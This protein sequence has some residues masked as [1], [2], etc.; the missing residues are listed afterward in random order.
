MNASVGML[1]E[2]HDLVKDF[3]RVRAV[4]GISFAIPRGKIVGL[5]GPN[6][7]GKT[8][9][10]HMLLGITGLTS[11]RITYF[12][13]EFAR[14]RQECLQRINYAS[15]FNTLQGRISV[16][17]N[18]LVFSNLYAIRNAGARIRKLAE[19]FEIGALLQRRYWDLSAGQKTRVNLIKALLNDPEL[20]LMDEPTASL[21]P[22]IADKTLS[23]IEE[24]RRTSAVSILYT[25]HDMEEVNRICDEVI[26]LDRGRIV[27]Q[28]TP[29]GLTKRI[30][31][32]HLK[33]TF[34][35]DL[36]I[37][38]AF[39]VERRQR[40][41]FPHPYAVSIDTTEQTIPELIFGI[42]ERGIWIT[43]IEVKKPTLEDVFL[44]IAR[45]EAH[46]K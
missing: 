25:S 30:R 24:A 23:L 40:H 37:V 6:G 3:G 17:E 12:G 10:I 1:L 15:S 5:L 8:T 19:Y 4:D 22:D 18:L 13:M 7:A 9:T 36:Q 20:I 32:A 26:F 28:D 42:S 11:G 21:D 33:L 45:G 44:R 35:G 43:D 39:L 31:N 38:K 16:W 34:D 46:V 14:H 29:L 27:A 41:T 2:V